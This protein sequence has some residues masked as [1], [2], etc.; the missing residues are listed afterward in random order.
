VVLR[1]YRGG[2]NPHPSLPAKKHTRYASARKMLIII[3]HLL[4]NGE[5]YVESGFKKKLSVEDLWSLG[6]FL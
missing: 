6:V 2:W 4:V 5:V 1:F 3:H